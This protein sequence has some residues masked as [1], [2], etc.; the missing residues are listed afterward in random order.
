MGAWPHLMSVDT[1]GWSGSLEVKAS[2]TAKL[3]FPSSYALQLLEFQV[4]VMSSKKKIETK[5][6]REKCLSLE[7]WSYFSILLFCNYL[8]L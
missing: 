8:E 3:A 5:Q 2:Y 4:V 1:A 6:V 7:T